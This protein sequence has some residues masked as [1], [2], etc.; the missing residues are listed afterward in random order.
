M[1]EAAHGTVHVIY[2]V[3]RNQRN[4]NWHSEENQLSLTGKNDGE[5]GSFVNSSSVF[6]VCCLSAAIMNSWHVFLKTFKC[7]EKMFS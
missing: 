6:W 1:G 3:R 5:G 2:S 4:V 7:Q